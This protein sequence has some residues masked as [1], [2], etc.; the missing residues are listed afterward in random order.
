MCYI[1]DV[2]QSVEHDHPFALDFL[3]FDCRNVNAFFK[4]QGVSV[5]SV[6]EIFEFVVDMSVDLSNIGKLCKILFYAFKK[7][8]NT[9]LILFY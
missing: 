4:K 8:F 3:R 7:S 5:P 9:H 2:S 1:I 6:R